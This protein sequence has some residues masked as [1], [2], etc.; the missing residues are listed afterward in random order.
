MV[1]WTADGS[2]VVARDSAASGL[3]GLKAAYDYTRHE[4]IRYDTSRMQALITSRG[5][6]GPEHQDYSDGKDWGYR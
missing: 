5:G 6:I 2:V 1:F 4:L 3:S